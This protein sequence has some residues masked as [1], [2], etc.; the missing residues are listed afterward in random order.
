MRAPARPRDAA[1]TRIVAS[2]S[3]SILTNN[4]VSQAAPPARAL[5]RPVRQTAVLSHD[6]AGEVVLYDQEHRNAVALNLTAA[7]IWDL[8]DGIN[9]IA[10]MTAQ[11]AASTGHESAELASDVERIVGE[12][13]SMGLLAE[14]PEDAVQHE[15]AE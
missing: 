2:S 5:L 11:L 15:Q 10:E 4:D 9:S 7:A 8:C 3:N 6:V 1:G 14:N 12:L 13:L